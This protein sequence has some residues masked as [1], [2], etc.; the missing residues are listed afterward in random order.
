MSIKIGGI[1]LAKSLI[2]IEYQLLR[3]QN[4]LE[5]IANNNPSIIKPS[6][7]DMKD[8]DQKA[9]EKLQSKYPDAGIKKE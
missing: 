9:L 7:D 4:L 5:W 1:D 2:N 3:T 8:I 6:S